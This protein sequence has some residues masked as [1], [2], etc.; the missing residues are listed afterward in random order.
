MANKTVQILGEAHDLGA[1]TAQALDTLQQ[2]Q[3]DPDASPSVRVA[4]AR[5]VLTVALDLQK[6]IE[7][8]PKTASEIDISDLDALIAQQRSLHSPDSQQ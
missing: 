5:A 4:A 8:A 1:A 7:A 6:T 2:V 3:S